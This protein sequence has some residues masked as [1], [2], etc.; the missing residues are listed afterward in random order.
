MT[1][2]WAEKYEDERRDHYRRTFNKEALCDILASRD[3]LIASLRSAYGWPYY[4]AGY[5]QR[6]DM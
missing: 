3:V 5:L 4:G 6:G 2:A 1:T